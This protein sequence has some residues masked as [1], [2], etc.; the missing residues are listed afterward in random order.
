MY[1][2][3]YTDTESVDIGWM[4][5]SPQFYGMTDD[6]IKAFIHKI[7]RIE[8]KQWT[9]ENR[10][11]LQAERD[12]TRA[13]IEEKKFVPPLPPEDVE[14]QF[15]WKIAPSWVDDHGFIREDFAKGLRK[16][17]RLSLDNKKKIYI[18]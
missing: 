13:Y 10:E 15:G 4:K 6:E 8:E 18:H 12:K 9:Q 7:N 2:D 11:R 5:Q 3:Y 1:Y 14:I 16:T 17:I